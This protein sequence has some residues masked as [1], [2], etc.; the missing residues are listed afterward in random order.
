VI[1]ITAANRIRQEIE[2]GQIPL[3]VPPKAISMQLPSAL[4]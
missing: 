3:Q 1:K 2:R 4:R